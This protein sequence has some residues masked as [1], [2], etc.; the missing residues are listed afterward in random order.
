MSYAVFTHKNSRCVG[1]V[2]RVC[3]IH[4]SLMCFTMVS[5]EYLKYLVLHTPQFTEFTDTSMPQTLLV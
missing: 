5:M 2:F 1:T 4:Y 3:V